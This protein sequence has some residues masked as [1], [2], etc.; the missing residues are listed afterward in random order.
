MKISIIDYG[1]GNIQSIINCFNFL[2]I[3]SLNLG[4]KSKVGDQKSIILNI[5]KLSKGI[6]INPA[7]SISN[8]SNKIDSTDFSYENFSR[9]I[10]YLDT[11][12]HIPPG[13]YLYIFVAKNNFITF[14]LLLL[15]PILFIKSFQA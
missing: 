14:N 8:G 15:Q 7:T 5:F 4:R 1:M 6:K 10:L 12:C 9:K 11:K 2:I 13:K 3:Y